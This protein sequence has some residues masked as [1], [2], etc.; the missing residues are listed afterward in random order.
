MVVLNL[1]Q[2]RSL[3]ERMQVKP[4]ALCR[5]RLNQFLLLLFCNLPE[6]GGLLQYYSL[7]RVAPTWVF[8]SLTLPALGEM[9]FA[10]RG[11]NS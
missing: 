9:A 1:R 5:Q 4:P 8:V 2:L 3:Q 6:G 11:I 7:R 10:G